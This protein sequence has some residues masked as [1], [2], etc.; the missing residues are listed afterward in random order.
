M[1]IQDN[2]E[3]EVPESALAEFQAYAQQHGLS[4]EEA[5]LRLASTSLDMRILGRRLGVEMLSEPPT[6]S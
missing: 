1:E 4:M 3:I 6:N 5:I 2:W